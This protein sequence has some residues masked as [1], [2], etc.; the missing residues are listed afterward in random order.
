MTLRRLART[1]FAASL[2]AMVLVLTL[3]IVGL[4][5]GWNGARPQS[6]PMH[7]E[8]NAQETQF[9]EMYWK[10][11]LF[12]YVIIT[13]RD[14]ERV[15]IR[16]GANSR[17]E[18]ET[19]ESDRRT[20]RMSGVLHWPGGYR[21]ARFAED[22]AQLAEYFESGIPLRWIAVYRDAATP[23]EFSPHF[24]I[25]SPVNGT[26]SVTIVTSAIGL[27]H[28]LLGVLLRRKRLSRG[29]CGTCGY[30]CIGD[31]CPECGKAAT[32]RASARF[33]ACRTTC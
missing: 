32:P 9:A 23:G 8:V 3:G 24:I 29:L 13:P 5:A 1:C 7:R 28:T 21:L 19:A 18:E 33:R 15:N 4:T 11:I 6:Q 17:D 30:P 22:D 2:A 14:H 27:G 10:R 26:L 16:I 20:G 12:D 31:K 25:A